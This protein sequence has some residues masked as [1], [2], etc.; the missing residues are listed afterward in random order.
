MQ[1]LVKNFNLFRVY[2][3]LC[4]LQEISYI[5]VLDLGF[6]NQIETADIVWTVSKSQISDGVFSLENIIDYL[7]VV[8]EDLQS[9]IF[10]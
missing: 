9:L 7:D 10:Y 6:F 8:V 3:I 4:L 1:S 5:E 2:L